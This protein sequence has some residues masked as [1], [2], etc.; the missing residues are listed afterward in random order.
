MNF[1]EKK[2]HIF[3][4]VPSRRLGRSLGI[5]VVPFKYCSFDCIYCQL[6]KTTCLTTKR[7]NFVDPENIIKEVETK[8]ND[9]NSIK[10]DV[11][12]ISGSGEPTLCL[13]L[14]K[15]INGLKKIS[16]IPIVVLTNSSLLWQD[17]VQQ[18]IINADIV[19]PSLDAGEEKIFK[20]INRPSSTLDFNKIIEGLISFRKIFQQKIWLEVFLISGVNAIHAD[21]K[22]IS[23]WVNLIKP[24]KVQLNTVS[25]PP[26]EDFTIP[27]SQKVLEKLKGLFDVEAEI[28]TDF[29]NIHNQKKFTA[30][31]EDVLALIKCRPCSIEDIA[32]GLGIHRNEVLKYI[33]NLLEINTIKE[34]RI[35]HNIFYTVTCKK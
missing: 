22:R 35:N 12:T 9:D 10:P 17:E 32:N 29:S 6:G 1:C 15:I 33:G 27:A 7:Q 11:L 4:P 20:H 30:T 25:R 3:G 14:D 8:L 31:K 26:A 2:T 23:D 21:V 5:D 19:I 24:D 13:G 28:I 18:E 34:K 16:D